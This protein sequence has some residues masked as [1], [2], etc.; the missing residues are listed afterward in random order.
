MV[1][2]LTEQMKN[3]IPARGPPTLMVLV[4]AVVRPWESVSAI[5]QGK[6][7]SVVA[8]VQTQTAKIQLR[9]CTP[10]FINMAG[11]GPVDEPESSM[12]G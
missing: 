4:K 7:T 5:M 12:E 8:N 9:I 2:C 6:M 1:M 11:F 10:K 3:G